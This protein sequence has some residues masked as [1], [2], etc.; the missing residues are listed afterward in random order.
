MPG[1]QGAWPLDKI[2]Q[3]RQA[4]SKPAA[5]HTKADKELRKLDLDIAEREL[6]IQR[7]TGSLVSRV[8]AKTELRQQHSA[9]K[10]RLEAI[11]EEMVS[12]LPPDLQ[13]ESLA[14]WQD[15]IE[16]I[17]KQIDGWSLGESEC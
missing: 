17:C 16:L 15:K 10:A 2:A 13:A 8:A 4:K 5:T 12:S 7:I 6:K 14:T 1:E 11:P 9:V 3:W